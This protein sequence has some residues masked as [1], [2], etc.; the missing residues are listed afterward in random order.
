MQ[1]DTEKKIKAVAVVHNETATGVQRSL[2]HASRL[3]RLSSLCTIA[4][5][6]GTRRSSNPLFLL[7]RRDERCASHPADDG[8]VQPSGAA[9]R[10]R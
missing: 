3:L 1:A 4:R 9:P 10:R 7:R 8:R 2:P 6:C 5:S